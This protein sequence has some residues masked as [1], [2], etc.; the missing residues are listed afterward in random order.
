DR[1]PGDVE[2][3]THHGV[4]HRDR[5]RPPGVGHLIP[6]PESLGTGHR[7][8]PDPVVAE[9]LLDL[10]RHLD[11]LVMHLV[12]DG[13]RAVDGGE[14]L[15]ELDVDDRTCDL[16]HSSLVHLTPQS[17]WPP[18]ISR[19]SRVMLPCLTVLYSR[20]RSSIR[21]SALSVAFFID[22]IRALCSLAFACSSTWWT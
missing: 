16:N 5:D 4:A 13:E 21:A 10:E 18:A 2:H 8:G 12:L 15:G 14:P 20:L 19:S 7:D 9:V 3:T 6:A 11:G 22:T 1:R 17:D